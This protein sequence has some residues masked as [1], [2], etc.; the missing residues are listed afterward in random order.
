MKYKVI[1]KNYFTDTE[2]LLI[3]TDDYQTAESTIKSFSRFNKMKV[4]SMDEF[5]TK[6]I[7]LY[8][9]KIGS[10]YKMVVGLFG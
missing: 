8:A 1:V 6:A 3:E 5:Q 4:V 2:Q 9:N 10:K 7:M